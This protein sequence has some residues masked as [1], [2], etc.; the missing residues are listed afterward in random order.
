MRG[1]ELCLSVLLVVLVFSQ[2]IAS[3]KWRKVVGLE[4]SWRFSIGDNKKWASPAYNDSEWENLRVPSKWEDQGFNGFNGYAWY[5]KSFDG[6]LL[7]NSSVPYHLFLGYIDDVDEVYLNGHLIG[8][9]GSFPP[10]YHTAFN[11]ERRYFLP[12]EYVNFKGTNVISVRVYD[13]EI[14]G[15]I[16]SG[17]VGIYVNENDQG[18]VINLRGVWDFAI[19]EKK[20]F[21]MSEDA[22]NFK[23]KRT[24]PEKANWTKMMVPALWEH[25]GYDRFDGTAWYRKQFFVPKTLEGE[26]L[27]LIMGKIDDYDQVYLN[28]KLIGQT[29][30]YDRLRIYHLSSEMMQAGA[31]NLLWIFVY[32]FGGFGGIYEGPVGFMKQ[33]EFT[34]FMRYR[35]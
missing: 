22:A 33:S 27:V 29:T 2:G 24:P 10:K 26:D 34:R 21:G 14:E 3:E 9:S 25:Q 12:A 19:A 5:R 11:A 31:Y 13:A 23:V 15:G 6:T 17:N 32:D 16:V 20:G 1:R 30:A 4:G 8:S 7:K 35:E 18:L 28:G